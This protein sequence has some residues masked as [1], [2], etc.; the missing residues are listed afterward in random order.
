MTAA[1]EAECRVSWASHGEHLVRL[2]GGLVT[3]RE[4]ADV[5]LVAGDGAEVASFGAGELRQLPVSTYL[6]AAATTLEDDTLRWVVPNSVQLRH[7]TPTLTLFLKSLSC[8]SCH[9]FEKLIILE[10]KEV[11]S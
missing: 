9:V 11:S 2:V 4:H 7:P 3:A 5:T 1:P 10:T 8:N 6:Q